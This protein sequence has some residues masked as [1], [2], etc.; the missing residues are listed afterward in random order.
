[1]YDPTKPY[2]EEIK[3]LTQITQLAA[4][5]KYILVDHDGSWTPVKKNLEFVQ[6]TD[7]VGSKADLTW[8][9]Y[10]TYSPSLRTEFRVSS[11]K[12]TILDALAMNL[13]D[14]LAM[15]ATALLTQVHLTIP[16]DD[17]AA[18]VYIMRELAAECMKYGIVITGGETSI[19]KVF[20]I[21]LTMTGVRNKIDERTVTNFKNAKIVGLRTDSFQSNG[22]SF[23]I[24][25]TKNNEAM[26]I[27]L[28]P[29]KI[30][31]GQYNWLYPYS[32]FVNITGGAFTRIGKA[33][34]SANLD[35]TEHISS[36]VN[37]EGWLSYMPKILD[38]EELKES[39][40]FLSYGIG[41]V[42]LVPEYVAKDLKKLSND[43]V[44]LGEVGYSNPPLLRIKYKEQEFIYDDIRTT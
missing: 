18:I 10:K 29:S 36:L 19:G 14:M 9:W 32:K 30:Y 37:T 5:E 16:E 44:L 4:N 42:V 40:K 21:S 20:D 2:I 26:S 43:F 7:G 28:K 25:K 15:E 24:S 23:I 12:T 8:Q 33:G 13:N 31:Y 1:M 17:H 38:I 35:M 27:A 22:F 11:L 3:K 6:H 41:M 34:Y 39:F